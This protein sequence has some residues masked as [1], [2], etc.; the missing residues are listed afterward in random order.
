MSSSRSASP[1]AALNGAD[2]PEHE[3]VKLEGDLVLHLFD[4]NSVLVDEHAAGEEG[5]D[6]GE[7]DMKEED[8]ITAVAEP[9]SSRSASADVKP[10][11]SPDGDR[12]DH[13]HSPTPIHT[14]SKPKGKKAKYEPLLIGDLPRAE[15]NAMKTFIEIRENH[16]QYSTLGRS[17]EALES[18]TCDCQYEHGADDPE[19]ACGHDSDCINRLTQVEC[20]PDDCRCGA[21]C[22]NQRYVR[23]QPSFPALEAHDR[24]IR[25]QRKQYAPIHIVQTEKKGFGLRA[26]EDLRKDTFIYEYVGDVVSQ[27]SFLKRMRQYAEEGIRHFYFMMLQKDEFIDAT[28]RGGIGRFANH[29]CNP[30]CYVAKWAVGDKVRMGIFANRAIKKDEELTFNYNVDRYGHEAQPCY[31]GEAKCVGYIGGKTQTDLAAMDDLYLDAL[32]ISEEVEKLGLKG[33]KK[34]KGKKLDEDFVPD[35]KPLTLKDVPKVVQAMMQT[36]SRKVLLKLLTRIKLTEDQSALRQVMRLRGFS[37]MSYVL[38][39]YATDV[40]MCSTAIECMMTWPLIQKNKVEDSKVSVPVK[41]CAESENVVL[42]ELAEKLLAQWDTLQYAY[43]IPKRVKGQGDPAPPP[44][45]AAQL[46]DGREDYRPP[47]RQRQVPNARP[48]F[49]LD[50]LA[51]QSGLA[52]IRHPLALASTRVTLPPPKPKPRPISFVMDLPPVPVYAK[53]RPPEREQLDKVIADAAAAAE[54]ERVRAADEAA[55][56]A[57]KEAERAAKKAAKKKQTPEEKEANKEKRLL[58]LVGAV[59]VKCMSKYQDQMDHE[60]FKKHAKEVIA[61]KEKKSHSYKENKLDALSEEK[62]VKIKKFAKEY[63]AKV[64]RKLEKAGQRRKPSSSVASNLGASTSTAHT[65]DDLAFT[66]PYETQLSHSPDA[67]DSMELD[68]LKIADSRSTSHGHPAHNTPYGSPGAQN[69]RKRTRS[70]EPYHRAVHSNG[71]KDLARRDGTSARLRTSDDA[72]DVDVDSD[73]RHH[74]HSWRA[75]PYDTHDDRRDWKAGSRSEFGQP[76]Q[77]APEKKSLKDRLSASD[78]RLRHRKEET[79]WDPDPEVSRRSLLE[80]LQPR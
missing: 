68:D 47:K 30:N 29:S 11:P 73:S 49:V 74:S 59:V 8:S 2:V 31:C 1:E 40:E 43:R 4:D 35:L 27:P 17:R 7:D 24:A 65:P 55:A 9:S 36:Q 18:M 37:V 39:E 46:Y 20:M 61:E 10:S 70:P 79:G 41:A 22:Q 69:G 77:E 25:F 45:T 48:L 21:Y 34:K 66:P 53:Y 60:V 75:S 72:M 54:A 19:D 26:A 13:D 14:D 71:W 67:D 3:A 80:R 42:K 28:K 51:A 64:L 23:P 38:G 56:A 57:A 78:P 63:I 33:N 32:G 52:N 12:S 76:P 5:G 6:G 44:P 50:A 58:K 16:Y 62:V 15:E